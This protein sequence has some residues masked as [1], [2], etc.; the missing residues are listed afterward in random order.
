[1]NA[2]LMKYSVILAIFGSLLASISIASAAMFSL[3]VVKPST[4]PDDPGTLQIVFEES[5]QNYAFFNG[6]LHLQVSSSISGVIKLLGADVIN[7]DDRWSVGI[8]RDVDDDSIGSIFAASVLTPGLMGTGK[9]PFAEIQY[10][11][12]GSGPTE[13]LIEAGGED[14]VVEGPLGEISH[15]VNSRGFCVGDCSP[16]YTPTVINLGENWAQ[17]RPHFYPPPPTPVVVPDPVPPPS[18]TLSKAANFSFDIVEPSTGPDDIGT[19]RIVFEEDDQNYAF[20]NGGLHLQVSSSTSG[21]IKLHGGEVI[22]GDDRWSVGTVSDVDDDSIGSIFAASV[23]TPGLT[24]EGPRT[25][26]EIHYS[27]IGSGSTELLIEAGGEDPVVEG[28][29]GEISHLVNSHGFCLGDCSPDYT[30]TVINLGENWAFKSDLLYP[31]SPEVTVPAPDLNPPVVENQPPVNTPEV[32]HVPETP[33]HYEPVDEELLVI[34]P[35]EDVTP[36]IPMEYP[37]VIEIEQPIHYFP[38]WQLTPIYSIVNGVITQI[39]TVNGETTS[40]L[41]SWTP[42]PFINTNGLE[43]VADNLMLQLYGRQLTTHSAHS[44]FVDF[45]AYDSNMPM[46]LDLSGATLPEPSMILL[47][48]SSAVSLVLRRRVA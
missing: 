13:L 10:S 22:N 24:G 39:N 16:D 17:K 3:E 25:F 45:A 34:L 38:S 19:L 21:V 23:L 32:S 14:P 12:I 11:L 7:H 44:F 5:D 31:P 26:A 8:V 28:P 15:L 2:C 4:G 27:L 42:R 1:M 30:P 29:L 20:F 46:A 48:C 33:V 9:R 36:E 47:V 43:S 40:V 6:G 35:D 18:V 41:G 37:Q